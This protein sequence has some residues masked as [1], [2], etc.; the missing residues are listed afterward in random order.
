MKQILGGFDGKV[1]R[2]GRMG[3]IFLPDVRTELLLCAS[4]VPPPEDRYRIKKLSPCVSRP[5]D[6]AVLSEA[7]SEVKRM[8]ASI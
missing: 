3:R 1:G 2:M 8:N 4:L 5:V 7:C 6:H